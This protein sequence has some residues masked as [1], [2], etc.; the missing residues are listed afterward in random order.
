[1]W[2]SRFGPSPDEASYSR[3]IDRL[4]ASNIL[5]KEKESLLLQAMEECFV[6]DE[7]VAID[8]SHFQA[9]DQAPAAEKKAKLEPKKRVRK[10]KEEKE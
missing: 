10:K 2:I 1:M 6:D 5:E 3:L 8:A 7:N 9:R 4:S